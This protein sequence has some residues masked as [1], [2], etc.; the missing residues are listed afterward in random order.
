MNI[1]PVGHP[2]NEIQHNKQEQ[3]QSSSSRSID[4]SATAITESVPVDRVQ[5]A[6]PPDDQLTVVNGSSTENP[7][8]PG[9]I[10]LLEVGHFKGVADVRLRINFF[11]ELSERSA[12]RAAPVIQERA[13]E[14]VQSIASHVDDL[15][16]PL[17]LN[18]EDQAAVAAL[19]AQFNAQVEDAV[20]S[21]S[22][23]NTDALAANLGSA[24]DALASQLS[25]LLTA[26]DGAGSDNATPDAISDATKLTIADG[27]PAPTQLTPVLDERMLLESGAL[28]GAQDA[29]KTNV[30]E[31]IQPGDAVIAEPLTPTEDQTG[32]TSASLNDALAALRQAFEDSLASLV[33]AINDVS[34]LS[35]PTA[36]NG[37]GRA[38]AKFLSAYNEL[39][40]SASTIEALA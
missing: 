4:A 27:Q 8:T 19:V 31:P 28:T 1:H 34:L 17:S 21:A 38:Y 30:S 3:S 18:E 11:D 14:L 6:A 25:D 22:P 13:D 7:N 29:A 35:E 37:N 9:V 36:P 10:R 40:S 26:T 24:F 12:E 16:V 5:L 39:R 33:T 20:T 32:N 23:D 15:V 2:A